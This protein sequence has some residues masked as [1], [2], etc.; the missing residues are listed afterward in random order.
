MKN[1]KSLT[2]TF[3][4][5]LLMIIGIQS[6]KKYTD[7]NGIDLTTT[8]SRVSHVWSVDNY[9]VNEVDLTSLVASYTE[10]FT[11][12]GLYTYKWGIIEGAGTWAFQNSDK[13]ILIT[14]SVNQNSK[15]LYILK[16][17]DKQFWYYYMDGTDRKEFHMI[18]K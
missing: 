10:T 1:K 16:L 4:F 8:K 9:K 18:E 11:S 7:N 15:T 2:A 14:G 3:L 5:S 13:E 6:C 12:E 17:Q